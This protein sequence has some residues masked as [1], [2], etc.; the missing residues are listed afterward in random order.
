MINTHEESR[1]LSITNVF[2]GTKH[3]HLM[4]SWKTKSL[5]NR[6]KKV[7]KMFLVL[8]TNTKIKIEDISHQ[9]QLM[10]NALYSIRC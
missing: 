2:I 9:P 6:I 10:I 1:F 3:I 7:Y 8:I 4:S 5:K